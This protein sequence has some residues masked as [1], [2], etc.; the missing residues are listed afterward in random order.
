VPLSFDSSTSD[1]AASWRA[2]AWCSGERVRLE[3]AEPLLLPEH[4]EHGA[5]DERLVH[6]P[7]ADP[8]DERREVRVT[9]GELDVD[10]GLERERRGLATVGGDAVHDLEERDREVVRDDRAVEAEP[11]AEQVGEQLAVRRDGHPVDLGVRVHH[12]PGTAVAQRHLERRQVHVGH[13]AGSGVHGRVVPPRL[14]RRV[15]EEVLQ[16]RVDPGGLQPAH[17]RGAHGADQVGVLGD[18]LV[19]PPP[20]RVP[21]DV[22]DRREALV[23]AELPHRGT[24]RGADLLDELRVERRAPRQRRRERRGL[25]RGEAGQ[26]L[27]V[28]E[29]GDP[30][31]GLALQAALFGPEPG[32]TLVGFDRTGAVDAGELPDAVAG[33]VRQGAALLHG[34]HLALHGGDDAVLVEPVADELGDLLVE[35][36]HGEQGVGA[37]AGGGRGRVRRDRVR[38]G[39]GRVRRAV[40]LE[41]RVASGGPRRVGRGHPFTAPVR[42]PTMRRWKIVKN[43]SAG[44]IDIEVNASTLAVSTEYCD[45][46][47]CTPSGSVY[48]AS[49]FRMNS[50][51]M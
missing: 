31:P 10:A 32:G 33:D 26:A 13:L 36:H 6:L 8:L 49:L 38:R 44:I 25:P 40:G 45:E 29:R 51:R 4:P 48:A 16:G 2:S 21:D 12:A 27:L 3:Q 14:R 46:N 17:V 37:G 24:D 34:R 22:E 18:A 9:R 42:P 11:V 43:T 50:G 5:V 20:T 7:A 35:G 39:R 1:L 15:P 28:H 41:A 47:D 19:D 30:E 23:D